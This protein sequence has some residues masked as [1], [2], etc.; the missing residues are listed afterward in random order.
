MVCDEKILS[1]IFI[2]FVV[3]LGTLVDVDET[4]I[5]LRPTSII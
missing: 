4:H 2:F 3:V 1:L 5:E